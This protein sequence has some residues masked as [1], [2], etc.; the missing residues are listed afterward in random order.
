V[1]T[2]VSPFTQ[3]DLKRLGFTTGEVK[4]AMYDGWNGLGHMITDGIIAWEDKVLCLA[5][6]KAG[7]PELS[8]FS[9]CRIMT[10]SIGERL[11]HPNIS[12]LYLRLA[13]ERGLCVRRALDSEDY[14][15]FCE[16][17]SRRSEDDFS[18][19]LAAV[20]CG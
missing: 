14:V 15:Y 13:Q 4:W 19:I 16:S 3:G 9:S 11:M 6:K 20:A 1:I 10:G 7:L 8:T 18:N 2:G 5:A 12:K 17:R